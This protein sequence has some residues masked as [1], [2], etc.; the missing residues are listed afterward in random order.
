MSY[1]KHLLSSD[2]IRQAALHTVGSAG[3]SGL[4]AM[5]W[6][7]L[8]TSFGDSSNGSC[9]ALAAFAKRIST[10]YVDPIGLSAYTA[11]C[12]IPSNKSPGIRPIG[13]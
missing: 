11:S 8:C 6:R 2:D 12:L 3:P 13:M 7:C 9:E 4:D 10:S 5:A 1:C